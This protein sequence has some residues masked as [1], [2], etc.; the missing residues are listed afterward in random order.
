MKRFC[1]IIQTSCTRTEHIWYDTRNNNNNTTHV[2][3]QSFMFLPSSNFVC[4]TF[5]DDVCRKY[6]ERNRSYEEEEK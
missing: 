5:S 1:A 3:I 4:R 6:H 2:A